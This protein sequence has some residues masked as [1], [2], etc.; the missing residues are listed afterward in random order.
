MWRDA[1]FEP[2][3][4]TVVIALDDLSYGMEARDD[5]G[6]FVGDEQFDEFT[7]GPDLIAQLGEQPGQAFAGFRGNADAVGVL[8]HKHVA[9]TVKTVHFVEHHQR[10]FARRADFFQHRV[11]RVNLFRRLRMAGVHDVQQQ[12]RLHDFL[13]RGLERLDEA[14]RQLANETHRVRQQNVL[15]GRQFQ[16]ARGGVQRGEQFVLGQDF[17]AGEGVE[18]RGFARVRVTHDGRER[19][20]IALASVALRGA[21]AADDVEFARDLGDAVL[22]AAAVGFQLRFTIPAHAD[23]AL[24]PGQVAPVP[25]QARE[26]VMQLREFNLQLALAGAGALRENVE[27]QRSAVEHLAIEHDFEIAALSGGKFIV[28]NDGVHV[29]PA[30]MLGEFSGLAAADERGGKGRLQFLRAVADDFAAGGGGQFGK[31]IEGIARVEGAAGFEFHTDEED[32]FGPFR[33]GRD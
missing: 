16:P 23:A 29:F 2:C 15:I 1:R 20:E 22:H 31:F 8:L 30:A 10:G 14:V 7:D 11:H 24:L 3:F 13:Q 9:I 18:Q 26:Q 5:R 19:P 25:R 12:I 27:N 32:S 6:G 21:L 28:K 4:F 33:C 17:R